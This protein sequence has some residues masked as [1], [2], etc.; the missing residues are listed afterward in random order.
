[1]GKRAVSNG[2]C[3]WNKVDDFAD[4]CVYVT[5]DFGPNPHQHRIYFSG[6]KKGP[7]RMLELVT[8]HAD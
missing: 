2:K 3:S 7:I 5:K 4:G 8:N 6:P 1:M